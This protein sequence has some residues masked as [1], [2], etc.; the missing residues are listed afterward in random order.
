[1]SAPLAIVIPTLN[2]ATGLPATAA[3]LVP[4]VTEGLVAELIVSDGGSTDATLAQAEA[5]G[6]TIVTG[7]AGRG[8][9]IALGVAAARAPF[10]LILHADSELSDDWIAAAADHMEHH[11]DKAGYFRLAFRAKGA[12]PAIIAGGA[13]LRSRLFGLPYGDQGLLV[14]RA[15][16]DDVGGVPDVPLMEDVILAKRLRGRLRP[17]EATAHTSADRYARQGWA[18]RA[19]SNLWTL[20]RFKAGA[21]PE[22]L[23]KGYARSSSRN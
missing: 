13:N 8:G 5:I 9:Q 23:A 16:L 19:A 7:P 11:R 4:G 20:A 15:V 1:M 3:R 12:A 22:T 6:A 18:R 2:A 10:V 14:A 17:L 21:D